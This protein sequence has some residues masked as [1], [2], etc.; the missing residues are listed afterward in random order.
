MSTAVLS[1]ASPVI[2]LNPDDN[3]WVAKHA[4]AAGTAIEG[5]VVRDDVALDEMS[6]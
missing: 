5:I 1:P 6:A 2:A 3:I 4:L